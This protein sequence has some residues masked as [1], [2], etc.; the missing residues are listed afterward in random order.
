MADELL[1]RTPFSRFKEVLAPNKQMFVV[2]YNPQEPNKEQQNARYPLE[3]I[4]NLFVSGIPLS[5]GKWTVQPSILDTLNG[6]GTV[7]LQVTAGEADWNGVLVEYEAQTYANIPLPQ[8]PLKQFAAI[9]AL[10]DGTYE[11]KLDKQSQ[12]PPTPPISTGALLVN[13]VLL[14]SEGA[15][16]E[17]PPQTGITESRVLELL[18]DYY[19][20]AEVDA[21]IAAIEPGTTQGQATAEAASATLNFAN[22][23]GHIRTEA[24]TGA[25]TFTKQGAVLG[26]TIVQ[27]YTADGTSTL[28]FD[29]AHTVL[30]SDFASGGILAAGEYKLFFSNWGDVVAVSI[31][32]VGSGVAPTPNTPPTI[33]LL[34]ANP[35]TLTQGGT[36]T[37]P[38]ATATDAEDG[39]ISGSIVITGTVDTATAGTYT[40]HYNVSDSKGLAATEVTRTVNVNP[41]GNTTPAPPTLTADDAANTLSASHAL[42]ASEILVSENGGAYVAYAGTIQVGNVARPVGYWKFK[43]RAAAGRN[44][45]AVVESPAFTF[46]DGAL[47]SDY[48]EGPAGP[49]DSSKWVRRGAASQVTFTHSGAGNL[50]IESK[51][52]AATGHPYDD[53]LLPKD[54]STGQPMQFGDCYLEFPLTTS[55]HTANTFYYGFDVDS[56]NYV[57]LTRTQTNY[58]HARILIRETGKADVVVNTSIPLDRYWRIQAEGSSFTFYHST[59][60]VTWTAEGPARATS[61]GANKRVMLGVNASGDARTQFMSYL[62]VMPL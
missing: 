34:G 35:M 5:P 7:T 25:Q 32:S 42:G 12:T 52:G 44:E 54:S 18:A 30:N 3:A 20:K 43:V 6:D 48:F 62:K 29:F 31:A 40:R 16:V 36:Y 23:F 37:E 4:F 41:A 55:I 61:I 28:T 39:D 49:V 46:E 45:S 9:A 1:N 56:A 60:G 13:Y 14:T 51:G 24:L 26:S 15:N 22:P 59:D 50:K 33:T 8:E 19:T 17:Q 2:G 47:F 21:L 53:A 58:G 10:E 57:V 38:G 27:A 11:L